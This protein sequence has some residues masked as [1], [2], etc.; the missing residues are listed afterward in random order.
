M[1]VLWEKFFFRKFKI[2][3]VILWDVSAQRRV[4]KDE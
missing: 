1:K 4:L 2:S 3:F